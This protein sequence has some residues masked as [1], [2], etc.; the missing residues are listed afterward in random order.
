MQTM[1][2]HAKGSAWARML[3]P[4]S[5]VAVAGLSAYWLTAVLAELVQRWRAGTPLSVRELVMASCGGLALLLLS[6]LLLAIA[7]E[8]AATLPGAAGR[9]ASSLSRRLVPALGRQAVAIALGVASVGACGPAPDAPGPAVRPSSVVASALATLPDPGWVPAPPVVRP[10]ADP[11]PLT[12]GQRPATAPPGWVVRQGDTLWDIALAHLHPD[13]TVTEVAA[14]WP[15]WY[16]AN[17]AVIGPDPDLL[18]PGQV[19][20]APTAAQAPAS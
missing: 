5:A 6:W 16:A 1:V 19:L 10:Q 15:R 2:N 13:A 7:L 20:R 4:L 8:L 18:Q 17:R 11:R 9:V 3:G 12:G 14:E